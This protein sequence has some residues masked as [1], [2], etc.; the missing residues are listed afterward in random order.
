MRGSSRLLAV[1]MVL[2]VALA[3]AIGYYLWRQWQATRPLPPPK[4]PVELPDSFSVDDVPVQSPQMALNLVGMRGT[5]HADYTDWSCLVECREREGCHA[6]VEV[7]VEY[8]SEGEPSRLVIGGRIDGKVG[9][10]M[11]IGRAQRP[12]VAVDGIDSVEVTV[13]RVHTDDEEEEELELD[14]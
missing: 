7:R 6:T 5:V 10:V 14:L 1:A 12:P 2:V 4:P 9:E 11:R 3:A 8:R 13:L